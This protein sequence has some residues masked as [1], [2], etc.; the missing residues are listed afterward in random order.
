MCCNVN[1]GRI[2]DN[3]LLWAIRCC[4]IEGVD[5]LINA[6]AILYDNIFEAACKRGLVNVVEK[7]LNKGLRVTSTIVYA[8]IYSPAVLEMMLPFCPEADEEGGGLVSTAVQEVLS[9]FRSNDRTPDSIEASLDALGIVLAA[10][11]VVNRPDERGRTPLYFG[12]LI[13]QHYA[14]TNDHIV[15]SLLMDHGALL[16]SVQ[17]YTGPLNKTWNLLEIP[18]WAV[19]KDWVGRQRRCALAA[20]IVL[21]LRGS[22]LNKDV[23]R[24]IARYLWTM[25][26]SREWAMLKKKESESK[27][28]L[29]Q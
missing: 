15:S 16:S 18:R 28:C 20:V 24:M 9:T 7:C 12:L 5:I 25:R 27:K 11:C 2:E 26:R 22:V 13:D 1:R 4:C 21:G 6:G 17:V 10:G 14:K 8:S 29:L 3:A 19:D 23:R